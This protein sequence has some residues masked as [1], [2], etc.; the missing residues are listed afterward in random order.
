M[1]LLD[2]LED[3]HAEHFNATSACNIAWFNSLDENQQQELVDTLRDV[4]LGEKTTTNV[5]LEHAFERNMLVDDA[6]DFVLEE[7]GIDFLSE[8]GIIRECGHSTY[9]IACGD[10]E[11]L[12]ESTMGKV[13][14]VVRGQKKIKRRF[15]RKGY[16]LVDGKCV[17]MKQAEKQKRKNGARKANRTG[18]QARKR[19]K[20]R[21]LRKRKTLGMD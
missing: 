16:K 12:S 14:K 6:G 15:C 3:A 1:K 11:I 13:K 19:S 4:A 5:M 9:E 10:L 18:K 20:E 21:S 2:L 8:L 17:P 7:A